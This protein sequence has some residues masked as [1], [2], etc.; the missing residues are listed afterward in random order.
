V[1]LVVEDVEEIGTNMRAALNK[2][3][4]EVVIASNADQAIQLAEANRP[5]MI[6]TDLDLPTFEN[7][8]KRLRAHDD[9]KNMV[10]AI[11]DINTPEISD[12]T[13]SILRSFEALDDLIRATAP[14]PTQ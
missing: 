13:V 6:L 2:R 10:V 11:L 3:G 5:T 12:K 14:S 1:I 7:L 9:L 8:M 4:H